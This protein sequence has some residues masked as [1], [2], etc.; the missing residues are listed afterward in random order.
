MRHAGRMWVR[1]SRFSELRTLNFEL[2]V[3]S[4]ALDLSVA[5]VP[6]GLTLDEECGGLCAS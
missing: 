2:Q 3:A 4:V 6:S 1:G 5:R